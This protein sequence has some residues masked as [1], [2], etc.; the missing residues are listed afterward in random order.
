MTFK[1]HI[2]KFYKDLSPDWKLP[3][4]ID[5]IYP[6]E[7][8]QVLKFM[9]AFYTKYYDD[10]NKRYFLFGINPGRLGAGVTG[11]PFTDPVHLESFCEIENDLKKKH[12]LSSI[13]I[14]D[15]INTYGGIENFYS[16]YYISSVCPLG[17]TK[18]NKNY[19]Y[20][21]SKELTAAV[22][23]KIIQAIEIQISKFCNREEAFSLGQGKN[24]KYLAKLNE[25]HEWFEKVTPLPHPRC[26]MQYK[27]K[28]KDVYLDEFMQKLKY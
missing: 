22:E 21:D 11:I 1:K 4:G 5:L 12:E 27:L 17:F 8:K 16:K 25:K 15:M 23:D 6:L 19:N 28:T 26:I 13:F 14:Y 7:N 3:K 2:L 24:Y 18:D 9:N 20:Y 10:K